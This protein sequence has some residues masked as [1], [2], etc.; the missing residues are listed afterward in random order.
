M[1]LAM[2]GRPRATQAP[3]PAG[4]KHEEAKIAIFQ[5]LLHEVLRNHRQRNFSKEAL[6]QNAKL[7]EANP[8][9][10][11][12]WNY[13]KLAVKHLLESQLDEV[14]C[15]SVL[16]EELRVVERA[17]MRNFK[18]Y[19]AWHHRKWVLNF[20]LSSLDH[21]Y[22]L[23]DKLLTSDAR[24]FH[25]WAYRRFLARV[26]KAT[27]EQELQYT[28]KKINEN[29]S[30]YSAWHSRSILLS[31][32]PMDNT[33]EKDNWLQ[34]LTEEYDLVKQAFFTE[35][36][37][38]SGWF[39]LIWLLS[40][41]VIP[42]HPLPADVN[43]ASFNLKVD[44]PSDAPCGEH[45][46][47][48][49]CIAWPE[50]DCKQS[51]FKC[52]HFTKSALLLESK[53]HLE[54]LSDWQ[55]ET[56][57][58]Q[59]ETCRELLDLE[60]DSKWAML[61]LARLLTVHDNFSNSQKRYMDEV[62]QLYKSLMKVDPTHGHYYDEQLS[63]LIFDQITS[64]ADS[65]SKHWYVFQKSNNNHECWLRL[66]NS[67]LS[68]LGYVERLIGVQRLDLSNNKLHSL[69]GIEMLQL[70]VNLDVSHNRLSSITTLRPI[71]FLTKL[72]A[73]NI[74]YNEIGAHTID[75]NRYLCSSALNNSL[76]NSV[77]SNSTRSLKHYNGSLVWEVL[78]V[79]R[80]L[81]LKQL[82][83]HGNPIS[84]NDFCRSQIIQALPNLV[85]LDG[86][87]VSQ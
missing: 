10:Y 59:I 25:G 73:L 66:N 29:F 41:T 38:Q 46:I 37:D 75:T 9:V 83:M 60:K 82:D 33:I 70:L 52:D 42:S 12:A 77:E 54:P 27:E 80:G 62:Q 15:K 21:E 57:K 81:G 63:L 51:P 72:E 32:Q 50:E 16:D 61:I 65:L 6:S 86:V 13:R 18:S 3:D 22:R 11:T 45:Q 35:P 23:L 19:G 43:H 5:S 14:A 53:R 28:I 76:D 58:A 68:K 67:S 78:E 4:Q 56:L 26:K 55:M 20:G 31:K 64:S 30:N 87:R 2:H 79:F 49:A 17:L 8:E 40:Q 47:V 71:T 69:E 39:Y 44:N 34:I 85:W 84:T 24:N 48:D 1:Q 74:K 7:L 36:E